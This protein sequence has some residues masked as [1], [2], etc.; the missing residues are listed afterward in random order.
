MI[1]FLL[2]TTL[3]MRL[4]AYAWMLFL[5]DTTLNLS[6]KAYDMLFLLLHNT[7]YFPVFAM[8]LVILP[9]QCLIVTN[10]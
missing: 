10:D 3:D 9:K 7:L 4:K 1:L 2:D 6:L 8:M 5:L